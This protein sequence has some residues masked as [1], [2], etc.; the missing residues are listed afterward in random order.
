MPS[1]GTTRLSVTYAPLHLGVG[2]QVNKDVVDTRPFGHHVRIHLT[3]V[4][5]PITVK[6]QLYVWLTIILFQRQAWV[7][8]KLMVKTTNALE[9]ER[10]SRKTHTENLWRSINIDRVLRRHRIDVCK[11]ICCYY[12]GYRSNP[13]KGRTSLN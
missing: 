2:L 13:I 6:Q 5:L 7:S 12:I 9:M 11:K 3:Q 8:R 4:I 10:S 1:L